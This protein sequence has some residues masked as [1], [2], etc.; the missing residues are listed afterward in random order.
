MT[1]P[2]D[3]SRSLTKTTTQES[4]MKNKELDMLP[5]VVMVYA[6]MTM[7]YGMAAFSIGFAVGEYF[8]K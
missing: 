5:I 8:V 4:N 6:A 3:L 7:C 2:P 1:L